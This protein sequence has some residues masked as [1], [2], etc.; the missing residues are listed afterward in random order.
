[1]RKR[2]LV[3]YDVSEKKR[4]HRAHRTLLGFGDPLQYSV[5]VCDVSDAERIT[6]TDALQRVLDLTEDRV[7]FVDLGPAKRRRGRRPRITTLG[8]TAA[9]PADE[10]AVVV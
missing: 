9:L 1:M 8:R 2:F 4:L 3:A 7:L 5:F 10:G 6:L